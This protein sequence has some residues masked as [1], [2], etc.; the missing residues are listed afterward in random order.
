MRRITFLLLFIPFVAQGACPTDYISI[1][2]NSYIS[3]H[4]TCP[5]DQYNLGEINGRC[6]SSTPTCFPDVACSATLTTSDG[7][8]IPTF[9]TRYTTPAINIGSSDGTTCYINML[10]GL[11]DNTINITSDSGSWHAVGLNKCLNATLSSPTS[12]T[13]TTLRTNWSSGAG[14]I[15]INGIAHCGN[16]S[17]SVG[18]T[19]P[20]ITFSTTATD[21]KYCYCRTTSPFLSSWIYSASY[22]SAGNCNTSCVSS[23]ASNF[24][25]NATFRNAVIATMTE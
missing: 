18:T 25:S 24:V 21:N 7:T 3:L 6:T 8:Q 16:Q 17:G 9:N 2:K 19:R 1:T 23:C 13:P 14:N 4:P 20:S 11:G 12:I 10:S 15:T 22:T 5:A